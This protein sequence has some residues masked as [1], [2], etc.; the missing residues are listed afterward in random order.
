MV[1]DLAAGEAEEPGVG[2]RAPGSVFPSLWG[3]QKIPESKGCSQGWSALAKQVPVSLVLHG[4]GNISE[5]PYEDI[6]GKMVKY[7]TAAV[8]R[9]IG[10]SREA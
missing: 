3:S 2:F 10:M 9:P 8:F 5:G 4:D 1:W 6:G 7:L